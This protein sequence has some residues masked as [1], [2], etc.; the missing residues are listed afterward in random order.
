MAIARWGLMIWGAFSL[1]VIIIVASMAVYQM[2]PGN[3]DRT[4]TAT[5]KDVRFVLNW[6]D[7]GDQRIEKVIHSHISARSFTGDHLDAHAIKI[8]RVDIDELTKQ[9]DELRGRWYRGDKLPEVVSEAVDFAGG[10]L[11]ELPWFPTVD[12]LRSSE[13]YVYPWSIH[14]H[15]AR[16]S[17]AELIFIRP[18]DKMVFYFGAKT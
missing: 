16:P 12:Q 5:A 14:L 1:C 17:A 7:L 15:G 13:F 6:C 3:R 11:H 10:W 2:G 18:S 4:Q 8:S 9:K